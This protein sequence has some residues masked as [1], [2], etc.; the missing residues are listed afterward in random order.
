MR[1]KSNI[2]VGIGMKKT[3]G[4]PFLDLKQQYQS[5]KN[6]GLL[7]EILVRPKHENFKIVHSVRHYS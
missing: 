3:T 7:E 1:Y 5:I 4:V 6:K 2:R